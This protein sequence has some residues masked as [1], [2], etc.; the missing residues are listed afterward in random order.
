MLSEEV[1]EGAAVGGVVEAEDEVFVLRNF[2]VEQ[3]PP[4]VVGHKTLQ[5]TKIGEF[6]QIC[7]SC[8]ALTILLESS[9]LL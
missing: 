1:Y 4:A 7:L 6:D 2:H 8:K 3:V 9:N 5:F